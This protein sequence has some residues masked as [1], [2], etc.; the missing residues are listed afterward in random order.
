MKNFAQAWAEMARE[1]NLLKILVF[2]LAGTTAVL[3]ISSMR[4]SMRDP[5]VIERACASKTVAGA[6]AAH[7]DLEIESFIKEAIASRFDSEA[8]L[9]AEY[10][11]LSEIKAREAEQSELKR[12]EITQRVLVTSIKKN[13]NGYSVEAD[14]LLSVGQVRSVFLFP[15]DLQVETTTRTA[16]NPYGL[17][18]KKITPVAQPTKEAK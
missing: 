11:S 9:N 10:F 6:G 12:R 14:R 8:T 5:L 2:A 15:L 13:G 3:G 4:L 17:V 1:N 18:L 16:T 7:T